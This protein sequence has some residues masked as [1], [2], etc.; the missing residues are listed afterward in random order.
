MA[1]IVFTVITTECI[2]G[3]FFLSQIVYQIFS[4]E[5]VYE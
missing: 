4:T 3:Y 2:V 5:M 1:F